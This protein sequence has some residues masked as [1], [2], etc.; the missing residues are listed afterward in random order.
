MTGKTVWKVESAM[1]MQLPLSLR[2]ALESSHHSLC[3]KPF[4]D[5]ALVHVL[6]F[7]GEKASCS[8]TFGIWS[9]PGVTGFPVGISVAYPTCLSVPDLLDSRLDAVILGSLCLGSQCPHRWRFVTRSVDWYVRGVGV[10]CALCH[11]VCCWLNSWPSF[12]PC[13]C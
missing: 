12:A 5:A 6:V 2:S 9:F 10:S 13:F 3:S 11:F 7:L 1:Q 4:A 8:A